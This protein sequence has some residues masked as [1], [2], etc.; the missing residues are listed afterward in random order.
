MKKRYRIALCIILI[1]ILFIGCGC[2]YYYFFYKKEEIPPT[3]NEVKVTNNIEKYGYTLE[4]RDTELFKEKFEELKE[5]VKEEYDQEEYLKLI[6]QLFIIDL[7]TINNKI[8]RYDIGG[9]EYVYNE[10]LPSFKS[11]VE[12]SIYKTVENNIDGKRTQNLPEVTSIEVSETSSMMY[13][14]PDETEVS[15][16][17]V[18]LTWTY[19]EDLGYD[20]KGVLILIPDDNKLA[21]VFYKPIN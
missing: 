19:K 20:T 4:D 12:S 21:V 8:S 2:G 1:L 3:I 14:M 17:R 10:A 11:V 6:S 9:L 13:T 5:L 18:E 15:G 16:Y 7:Y